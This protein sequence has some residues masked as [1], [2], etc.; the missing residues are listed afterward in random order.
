METEESKNLVRTFIDNLSTGNA[1]AALDAFAEDGSWWVSGDLPT[2][3]KFVG[4][5]AIFENFFAGAAQ[6]VEPSSMSF[7]LKKL[8]GEGD[9]VAVEWTLRFK[10]L[11]GRDYKNDYN[12]IFELKDGKIQAIR[13]YMDTLYAHEVLHS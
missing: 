5:Q 9:C 2:S 3:G 12:L 4:K 10:T 7:E 11:A 6:R 8:I 1:R 13:E